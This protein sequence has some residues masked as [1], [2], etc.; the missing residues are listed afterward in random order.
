MPEKLIIG[1]L[2]L[3]FDS[4]EEVVKSAERFSDC[5]HVLL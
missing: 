4:E 2:D 1:I 3:E 5:P